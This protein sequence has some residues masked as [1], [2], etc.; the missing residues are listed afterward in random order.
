M[1]GAV[2]VEHIVMGGTRNL[3]RDINSCNELRLLFDVITSSAAA[4]TTAAND[5]CGHEYFPSNKRKVPV[6][7]I[8]RSAK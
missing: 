3:D 8:T 4:A 1:T 5:I 2:E 6:S 7:R